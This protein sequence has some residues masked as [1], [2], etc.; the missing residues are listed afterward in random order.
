MNGVRVRTFS[1]FYTLR[2]FYSHQRDVSSSPVAAC[3]SLSLLCYSG[4][5]RLTLYR[6]GFLDEGG[7]PS[8]SRSV[9]RHHSIRECVFGTSYPCAVDHV[10]PRETS[11]LTTWAITVRSCDHIKKEKIENQIGQFSHTFHTG[12]RKSF[13]IRG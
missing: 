11:T 9:Y 8:G 4:L 10:H 7:P 5:A 6:R 13:H 12:C 1:I 3:Y 2:Q